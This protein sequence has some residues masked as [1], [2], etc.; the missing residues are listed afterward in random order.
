MCHNAPM[1]FERMHRMHSAHEAAARKIEHPI[2][3]EE[4]EI[5][6]H[7]RSLGEIMRDQKEQ[8]LFLNRYLFERDPALA[9]EITEKYE[10]ESLLSPAQHTAMEKARKEY[11]AERKRV[12]IISD[13]LTADELN[14]IAKTDKNIAQVVGQV[15]AEECANF[16]R[17]QFQESA[18]GDRKMLKA[19]EERYQSIHDI[20]ESSRAKQ[21][22]KELGT[23]LRLYSVSEQTFF[24]AVRPNMTDGEKKEKLRE[25]AAKE[26]GWFRKSMDFVLFHG[27]SSR[28]G[29]RL[30]SNVEEQQELLR[31]CD[32]HRLIIANYLNGTLTSEVRLAMQKNMFEGG[33]LVKSVEKENTDTV[34]SVQDYK[35]IKTESDPA[36]A[37]LKARYEAYEKEECARRKV[38]DIS[39]QPAL[40]DTLKENFAKRE[41]EKRRK[42]KGRGV[43]GML[44]MLLF[45]STPATKDD[46]KKL[47]P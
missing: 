36:P 38:K 7:D 11:N 18:I 43:F 33:S 6:E 39:K 41:V 27:L 26:Y 1:S 24:D 9:Q 23:M 8:E 2:T 31:E 46:I 14:A 29:N 34:T 21:L 25:A 35:R 47:L 16:L 22:D 42:Y 32:K 13:F 15:G 19:I 28:R 44:L 30:F 40:R 5:G 45:G 4:V 12:E 20:G 17:T 37:A 3:G 10:S